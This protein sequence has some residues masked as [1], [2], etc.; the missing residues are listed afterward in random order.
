MRLE[1]LEKHLVRL[2]E[3]NLARLLAGRLHPHEV[4]ARLARALDENA[5]RNADGSLTAPDTFTVR[6]CSEDH[7][8]LTADQPALAELLRTNILEIAHRA[9]LKM[10]KAPVVILV[11]DPSL[12]AFQIDVNAYHD[13]DHS[14]T[15]IMQGVTPAPMPTAPRNPQLLLRGNYIPLTRPVINLG[16]RADNHIVIDDPY[17]SR[18][19]AQMR[20]RFGRYV[21]YDLNSRGGTFVNNQRVTECLLQ[22][23][24]V[25]ALS[26]V[27]M[28]YLEDEPSAS[29]PPVTDTQIRPPADVPAPEAWE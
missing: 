27:V 8:A 29:I 2:I 18:N 17:I 5:Y 21:I 23:N 11:A 14:E 15:D 12:S 3:G 7:A 20:L 1:Q 24:D 9:G 28:V 26:R 4:A 25:I 6:L 19:H 13:E 16:R 10:L 22:P